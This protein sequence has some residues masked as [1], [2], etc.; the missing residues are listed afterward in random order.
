M[1]SAASEVVAGPRRGGHQPT[2]KGADVRRAAGGPHRAGPPDEEVVHVV[3]DGGHHG[4]QVAVVARAEQRTAEERLGNERGRAVGG[5]RT[6]RV[7][8]PVDVLA[9]PEPERAVVARAAEEPD[10]RDRAAVVGERGDQLGAQLPRLGTVLVGV[11]HRPQ[12]AGRVPEVRGV[13]V[14]AVAAHP[15][16]RPRL[17]A[18]APE[19]QRA[20]GIDDRAPHAHPRTASG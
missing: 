6:A 11:V 17:V 16:R 7:D 1:R 14:D 18:V 3:A 4:V 19:P 15:T 13:D 2:W 8:G 12:Q 9:G 10:H 5:C 20:V